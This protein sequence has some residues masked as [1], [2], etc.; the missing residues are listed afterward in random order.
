MEQSAKIMFR[1]TSSTPKSRHYQPDVG[2]YLKET[3]KDDDQEADG[4]DGKGGKKRGPNKTT[5]KKKRK[6]RG[7]KQKG[8]GRGR[9]KGGKKRKAGDEDEA[10]EDDDAGEASVDDDDDQDLSSQLLDFF[11]K[12]YTLTDCCSI[13]LTRRASKMRR[14][15]TM[16][17]MT[18]KRKKIRCEVLIPGMGP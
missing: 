3:S 11:E 17:W 10:D 14:A 6:S 12:G 7:E 15:L 13:L 16:R 18:R 1:L 8:K 5:G 2:K 9:G 4:K